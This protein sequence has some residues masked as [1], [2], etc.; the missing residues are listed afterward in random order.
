MPNI[1]KAPLTVAGE[2]AE[3]EVEK[4]LIDCVRIE[5]T[6]IQEEFVRIPMDLSYWN[7]R[8]AQAQ[9][10]W[11]MAKLQRDRTHG[12]A[13]QRIRLRLQDEGLKV[14]ESLVQSYLETDEE[15][16]EANVEVIRTEVEKI[17]VYGILDAIRSKKDALI[18]IGA[19]IRSELQGSPQLRE[20]AQGIRYH[21]ALRRG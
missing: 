15:M 3:L 4:Y 7:E 19:H 1:A 18:S 17:R 12:S 11:L 6:L 21:E 14:T 8:Y 20:Q 10:A 13:D 9:E 2:G 16:Y 5:P